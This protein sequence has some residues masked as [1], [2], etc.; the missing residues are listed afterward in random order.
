MFDL[1]NLDSNWFFLILGLA[2]GFVAIIFGG[3]WFVDSAIWLAEITKIPKMIIGATIVSI[4]TS[5]PETFVSFFAAGA[6]QTGV[7]IGNATGS[8]FCNT[9]LVLAIIMTASTAKHVSLRQFLPKMGTLLV[10]T[11]LITVF[12]LDKTLNVWQSAVLLGF[13]VAFFIYNLTDAILINRRD[14]K[15]G[16]VVEDNQAAKKKNPA[17]MIILFF[18]GA[19]L[20]AVGANFLV[21]SVSAMAGKIGISEQ[22]ISLTVVALGTSLPE[23]VTALNSLKKANTELSMGNVLGANI[24]NATMIVGG[25]GLIAGGLTLPDVDFLSF[26]VTVV[27]LIAVLL[28][29]SVPILFKRRTYRWQGIVMLCS[30]AGYLVFLILNTLGIIV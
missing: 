24:L 20:I 17:L 23:L 13:A 21:D 1:F 29:V 6:G 18:V 16:V 11:V 19:A 12:S 22:I 2:F 7:A 10:V 8:M 26:L 15:N 14:K 4:G 27:L 3:D 9:A 25:S 30:Y 28:V 5:L